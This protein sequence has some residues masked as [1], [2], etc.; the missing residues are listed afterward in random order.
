MKRY[1]FLFELASPHEMISQA[2][3]TRDTWGGSVLYSYLTWKGM[4]KAME[5]GMG[6]IV[7][8]QLSDKDKTKF[9]HTPNIFTAVISSPQIPGE[10]ERVVLKEWE[11]LASEVKKKEL[12]EFAGDPV[13]EKIWKR[14]I[15]SFF[16]ERIYW[17]C[18]EIEG[19]LEKE[20][21]LR[22][23]EYEAARKRMRNMI[24]TVEEEIKCTLCGKREVLRVSGK[25]IREFW[26]ELREKMGVGNI[27]K[28]ERLCAV[29]F[30]KRMFLK[31]LKDLLKESLSEEFPSVSSIAV[32]PWVKKEKE[33]PEFRK[34]TTR[35]KKFLQGKGVFCTS[36]YP[37]FTGIGEWLD[38]AWYYPDYL[39][40]E[41]VEKEGECE[42]SGSERKKLEKI[43]RELK[44][45]IKNA[46]VPSKYLALMK[47]DGD[48]MGRW[49]RGEHVEVNYREYLQ[50]FSEAIFN[51]SREVREIEKNTCARIVYAGG[52]DVL[53]FCPVEDVFKVARWVRECFER[54]MQT[55]K[56]E[57]DDSPTISC[58]AV[59]FHHLYP[60]Y[61]VL[62]RVEDVLERT[63]KEE[64]GRNAFAIEIIKGKEHKREGGK[65]EILEILEK[66]KECFSEGLSPRIV[67]HMFEE[68]E[69]ENVKEAQEK[70]FLRL[71]GR[72]TEKEVF[73]KNQEKMEGLADIFKY[74]DWKK[75]ATLLSFALTIQKEER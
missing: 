73:R 50:R 14:Q 41:R 46:G 7:L 38:G 74:A 72:H 65:W 43:V 31:I 1:I 44:D 63:A 55:I 35:I 3:K 21:F 11:S 66:A 54:N 4:K 6:E 15:N 32:S 53:L 29:C 67:Y 45:F 56:G 39:T 24:Q 60:L 26:T 51:F 23:S 20:D 61:S 10:V 18:M 47:F 69:M 49:I 36:I 22:V 64:L 13:L 2:R 27:R 17:V 40:P 8:P 5:D 19:E 16:R 12:G 37:S 52:D 25:D 34:I 75:A 59:I 58:G 9:L 42:L 71:L 33:K 70:E 30:V 57:M 48:R 28:G 62:E 68:E